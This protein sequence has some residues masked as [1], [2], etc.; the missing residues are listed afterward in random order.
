MANGPR[1]LVALPT[2]NERGNIVDLITRL[3][4][5][6]SQV[7]VLVVDDASPD[8]TSDLVQELAS[9]EPRVG[10]FRRSGKLGLGSAYLA[11]F[12]YAF[13]RDYD[14]VC[15]MDADM[16][17]D[18][19]HLPAMIALLEDADVVI[20]SRYCRGGEVESFTL[21]RR[22]NSFGANTLAR[23]VTGLRVADVTSGYRAYSIALLRKMPLDR[24]TARGYALLVELL[25]MAKQH[26]A[27]IVESP[28]IFRRRGSGDSKITA[29]EILESLRTLGRIRITGGRVR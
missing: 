14:A 19:A 24:L 26:G 29:G 10:L 13:A 11:A 8:G 4:A 28:I 6:P 15:T 17:H 2:Y 1:C 21:A 20:G 27:R 22:I 12:D 16:S 9:R 25:Y 7:D 3:L 18:P 23:L 5:L